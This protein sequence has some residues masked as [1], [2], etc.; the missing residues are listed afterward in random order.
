MKKPALL[1]LLISL[2]LG[3]NGYGQ[4]TCFSTHHT[5]PWGFGGLTIIDGSLHGTA[6]GLVLVG[7][8]ANDVPGHFVPDT[9]LVRLIP[10]ASYVVRN[11]ADGKLY[12]TVVQKGV[13]RLFVLDDRK[14]KARSVAVKPK[15]WTGDIC[16][17]A[18]SPDGSRM[19]FSAP[20]SDSLSSHDL[21]CS[22]RTVDGWERPVNLGPRLNT[23]GDDWYPVFYD[24]FLL[25]VS[26]GHVSERKKDDFYSVA[27]P[28][29][30]NDDS[31]A[32]YPYLLQRL[33]EPFNSSS[34]DREL[35]LD[36]QRGRGY[37]LSARDGQEAI[38]LFRGR[39][40]GVCYSGTVTDAKG[41]PL[42]GAYVSAFT[43]NR[44]EATTLTDAKGRYSLFLQFGTRY[45]LAIGSKGHYEHNDTLAVVGPS[46]DRLFAE[47]QHDVRLEALPVG[48]PVV[49]ENLF[50]PAAD[51]ELTDHGRQLLMP[52]V[53]M[54]R[55][56]A[57]LRAELSLTSR[58]SD[59]V[60][61]DNMLNERRINVLREFF[62]YYLSSSGRI[63]F[64]ESKSGAVSPKDAKRGDRLTV[65][66]LE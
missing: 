57:S 18:F 50:G 59:N 61:F 29:I 8:A 44:M 34:N 15:G 62:D 52:V 54:L 37:W 51:I 39:L 40:D 30:E 2:L 33:P 28:N 58:V 17:P 23:P 56:N 32:A 25:F 49:F 35:A 10:E 21:W 45:R 16:H 53:Q 43:A 63:S 20:A 24:G 13:S 12:Y 26:N 7:E 14:G 48:Q 3:G 31:L 46:A 27:F 47:V 64:V 41:R 5:L 22:R 60:A 38:Y 6:D 19:V 11:A 65:T 55:E 42:A 36:S 1:L 66:F 9:T 4:L